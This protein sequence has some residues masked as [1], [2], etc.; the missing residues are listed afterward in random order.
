M[1]DALGTVLQVTQLIQDISTGAREQLTGISQVN[2][3]VAQLDTITQQNAA[4]VEQIA[5]SAVA[6]QSRA[7]AVADAVNVFRVQGGERAAAPDAPVL[8]R[9][10][11]ERAAA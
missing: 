3:A 7:D 4:L 5:A 11:K 8:R 6:L 2:Q 10:A 9:Q 1:N